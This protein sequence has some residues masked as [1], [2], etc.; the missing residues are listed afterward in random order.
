VD[1]DDIAQLDLYERCANDR[2]EPVL[3]PLRLIDR[4]GGRPGLHDFEADLAGGVAAIEVTSQV[5]S[6]RLGLASSAHQRYSPFRLPG[7][8]FRWVI[9]LASDAQVRKLTDEQLRCLLRDM[10][11][12]GCRS[13]SSLD[14]WGKP[15]AGRLA[16]LRIESVYGWHPKDSS[17]QGTVIVH[18]G[19]YGG[20][21][22][23][24][25]QIDTWLV[26]LLA[27]SQGQNK[28]GKLARARHATELHLVI[29]IDPFSPPGI[30]IPVGLVDIEEAEEDDSVL[31]SVVPPVPLTDMWVMP[32]E[33]S[34]GGLR[35]SRG[36]HWT[37]LRRPTVPC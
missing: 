22:W 34:W 1:H 36:S 32:M 26:D 9:Q 3:G 13:A 7:S 10:E 6:R 15:F 4:R 12:Q 29:V 27:S 2:L 5:D 37:I 28:V 24:G 23:D 19:I 16:E 20:W 31:P 25:S 8:A 35:W 11:V 18:P 30:G 14:A 33:T 17:N 21:G